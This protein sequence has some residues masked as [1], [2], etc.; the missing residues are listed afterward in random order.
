MKTYNSLYSQLCSYE[1]LFSAY[2]KARKQKTKKP[3]V[4]EFEKELKNNLLQLKADLLFHS[5]RPEPLKTFII[6]DPKTRKISKSAFRDRV[7]HHALCNIIEPILSRS[8]IHDSYANRKGKGTLAAIKR[9]EFFKRKVSRNLMP[10]Q[11]G[12]GMNGFVLKADIRK[13]FDS[14]SQEVLLQIISRK[15][16]DKK[17]IWLI[18]LILQNHSSKEKGGGMPLGN[19]TSQFF[20][21]V[22]LNE[23]DYFIKH[24]LKAKYYIRYVDDF[25]IMHN[26][27]KAL[28]A[29]K[30]EISSFLEK[31]L[32]LKLHAE[33]SR[34]FPLYQGTNFLGLKIFPHHKLIQKKNIRAFRKKLEML[35]LFYDAGNI[36]YDEIYNCFEGWCAYAKTA[37]AYKLKNRLL[38]PL[39]QKFSNEL[40]SKEISRLSKAI[41]PLNSCRLSAGG[42]LFRSNTLQPIPRNPYKEWLFSYSLCL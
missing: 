30:S 37:D 17:V 32:G 25:V 9:F 20:A 40:S 24:K 28:E 39:K 26:S 15:I 18:R 3:Y 22:Y 31:E 16:A 19:L 2:Q 36:A 42:K 35:C 34:I 14:V 5:Y 7:V 23:M 10:L 27:R 6:R 38:Q 41:Y 13:F 12:K 21:N 11:N 1:N 29:Y 8:F 33:K 4:L